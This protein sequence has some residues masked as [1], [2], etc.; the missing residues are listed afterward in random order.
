MLVIVLG[1]AAGGGFPQWNC[2]C[3]NCRDVRRGDP[4]LEVR[5]QDSLAVS[6]DGRRWLLLNASPDVRAQIE[7]QPV[8]WPARGRETPISA[9]ALSNGDLDHCLGLFSLRESQPLSI[10]AT[11]A[12]RAGLV[13]HNALWATLTRRPGQTVWHELGPEGSPV[14]GARGDDLGLK[15]T[16]VPAAGRLPLHL[17]GRREPNAFDNVAL[18]VSE[19]SS[20]ALLVYA[21]GV[22]APSAALEPWLERA[23]AVFFDGTFS[24]DSELVDLGLGSQSATDMAH[25]PL[26]SPNGSLEYLASRCR[27][28]GYLTHVNNTNPLL[29]AGSAE[30]TALEA[31]GL[32]VARD[33]MELEL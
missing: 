10:Y 16:P 3:P 28:R 11:H 20:K 17:R 13:D 25:W 30:R 15:L 14:T 26:F 18:V 29:R 33:G 8:L 24:H 7:R 6:A 2:A 32:G 12:V 4:A 21:P 9:I 22:A 19:R 31:A 27:G 1:S 5:T 23:S